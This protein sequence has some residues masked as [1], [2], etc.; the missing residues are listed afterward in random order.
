MIAADAPAQGGRVDAERRKSHTSGS[1]C[2]ARP[3]DRA[4]P[5]V[6]PTD[7]WA[8]SA[9]YR[10]P[11][12]GFTPRGRG[13]VLWKKLVSHSMRRTHYPAPNMPS[14]RLGRRGGED[15]MTRKSGQFTSTLQPIDGARNYDLRDSFGRQVGTLQWLDDSPQRRRPERY[16]WYLNGK[17]AGH[18]A[19]RAFE[20]QGEACKL[21]VDTVTSLVGAPPTPVTTRAWVRDR[22]FAMVA[23][24]PALGS[25]DRKNRPRRVSDLK[26]R[27]FVDKRAIPSWA[28][29]RMTGG[30]FG[31]GTQVGAEPIVGPQ[32]LS[33][34]NF[35]SGYGPSRQYMI[36]QYFGESAT[37]LKLMAGEKRVH[38]N[39]PY[40]V[41]NARPAFNGAMYAMIN[42]TGVAGGG[43]VRA[44]VRGGSDQ[45]TLYDEM[46]YCD[47]NFTLKNM[48]L[49]RN[50]ARV[51]KWNYFEL[52]NF[53][54]R[55]QPVVRWVYGAITPG[56]ETLAPEQAEALQNPA[57]QRIFAWIPLPC[58]R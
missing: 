35:R 31:C 23:F 25:A 18:G 47:P 58:D 42:T 44:L 15:R 38:N 12:N 19:T 20:I 29:P 17:W 50:G 57:S 11:F 7:I 36:G 30:D 39:M 45:F 34:V 26:I 32:P 37:Q 3:G 9:P 56:P 46:T 10:F 48:L 14:C 49:K 40:D 51:S 41:Y 13:T 16:G 4:R 53:S 52:A 27:A 1:P 33:Y 43:M 22:G 24:N 8:S 6:R 55:N 2:A 5:A 21:R 54:S 28:F